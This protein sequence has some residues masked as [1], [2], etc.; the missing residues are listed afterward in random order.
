MCNI[1]VCIPT[2]KRSKSGKED[3]DGMLL[4]ATYQTNEHI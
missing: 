2:L 4:I 3:E 1:R